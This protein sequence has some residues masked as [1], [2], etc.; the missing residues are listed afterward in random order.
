MKSFKKKF[1]KQTNKRQRITKVED[2]A[3]EKFDQ[4]RRKRSLLLS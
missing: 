4:K 3:K 2:E 1:L